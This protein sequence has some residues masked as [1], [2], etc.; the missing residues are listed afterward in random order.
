MSKEL[1]KKVIEQLRKWVSWLIEARFNGQSGKRR[2]ESKG[3][4]GIEFLTNACS[5]NLKAVCNGV[6]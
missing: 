5:F 6:E 3:M 1:E 2:T 4:G